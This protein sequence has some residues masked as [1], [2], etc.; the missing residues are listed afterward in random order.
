MEKNS[1]YLEKLNSKIK[2]FKIYGFDIE[3]YSDL[4][5][6]L[7]GSLSCPNEE[8]LIFYEKNKFI[9]ALLLLTSK[10]NKNNILIYATNLQFD[11]LGLFEDTEYLNNIYF[12]C[13]GSEI[14]GAKLFSDNSENFV[15]FVDTM[16]IA[17]YSVEKLGE[18]LNNVNKTT[19]YSKLKS[20]DFLGDIPKT[21]EDFDYLDKYNVQDSLITRKFAEF[22]QNSFNLLGCEMKITIAS[23]SMDL[24]RRKYLNISLLQPAKEYLNYF[25]SSYYGGRTE[26][27]KRGPVEKLFYYDFNSLYP[28]QYIKKYPHPNFLKFI[29]KD[30]NLN[31]LNFEGIC[32]CDVEI[33][34]LN[35][36]FLPHRGEGKLLFP[37]GKFKGWWTNVELRYALELGYKINKIYKMIYYTQTIELFKNFGNELYNLRMKYKHEKNPYEIVIKLILNSLYGKFAQKPGKTEIINLNQITYETLQ[38]YLNKPNT[39]FIIGGN[40]GYYTDY[41]ESIPKFVNPIISIYITAYSRIHLYNAF[42][43]IG[44]KNIYYCDT[45][46]IITSEKISTSENLGDLKLE[47]EIKHGILVKPK[48]YGFIDTNAKAIVKCKGIPIFKEKNQSEKYNKFIKLIFNPEIIYNSFTKFREANRSDKEYKKGKL[49]YNQ[50]QENKKILDLEDNKRVWKDKFCINKLQISEPLYI[51]EESKTNEMS[52]LPEL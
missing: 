12:I 52:K 23:T 47:Y 39:D 46:S 9:K 17:A 42:I 18:I 41:N 50:I 25:Y 14:I 20:P 45:D 49:K 28:S 6:F 36:P 11:L 26:I 1:S 5:L 32:E 10:S 35:I 15:T 22:A 4:N 33:D 31:F 34:N 44:F 21:N 29:D 13:R 16:N 24:F 48:F 51:N 38:E 7:M 30:I 19:I 2:K 27:F 8:S 3:T 43:K 37:C 40:Y